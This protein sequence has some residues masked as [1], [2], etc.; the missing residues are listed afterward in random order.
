[1][2]FF[3]SFYVPFIYLKKT[4][5]SLKIDLRQNNYNA[6]LK[7]TFDNNHSVIDLNLI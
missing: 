3:N 5:K 6:N 4:L 1:M 2:T 7:K